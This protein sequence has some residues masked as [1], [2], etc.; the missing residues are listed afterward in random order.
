MNM[1]KP[2]IGVIPLWDDAR[3]SIWMIPGYMDMIRDAGGVPIILPL[4]IDSL[5]LPQLLKVCDGVLM[6]GGHDVDPELYSQ[7]KSELCG[8]PS[9]ERDALE[10]EVF[11][12]A[13]EHDLPLLGICR[14]I[15]LINALCGGTLYQDLPTEYDLH[16]QSRVNHQ[17]TPPYD[18]PQHEV[19]I[20]EGGALHQIVGERRL[21]VNSYHHQ[22]IKELAP[23][24]SATA[25]SVDGLVE[26]ISMDSRSFVQAV[27]WH[28]E[29][30]YLKEESS[31]R[32]VDSFIEACAECSIRNN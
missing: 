27:Q 11:D 4:K 2:T 8:N 23:S 17:M 15:Q 3:E 18:R 22:A 28:P 29:L 9:L 26:A 1:L 32:L 19:D 14:G 30:N 31:R 25:Y 16:S 24:L 10:R 5:D 21:S 6:T 12:Y 13:M 7:P 20:V